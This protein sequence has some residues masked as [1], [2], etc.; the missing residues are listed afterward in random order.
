MAYGK[1][2]M[3]PTYVYIVFYKLKY[4]TEEEEEKARKQWTEIIEKWPAKVRLLG[5]FDHAWGTNY[6]GFLMLESDSMDAF[7]EFWKWFRDQ[8]RW[9]I[10]DTYTI[11]S[12][13]R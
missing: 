4:M 2:S 1:V 9:Y 7:A 3:M 11:I 8:I 5:V 12:L 10:T 6:N 13:R